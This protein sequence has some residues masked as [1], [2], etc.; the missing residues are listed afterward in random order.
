[1]QINSVIHQSNDYVAQSEPHHTGLQV[2][3]CDS[4]P[5][6]SLNVPYSVESKV[7]LS[8]SPCWSCMRKI[9]VSPLKFS[10]LVGFFKEQLNVKAPLSTSWKHFASP[11]KVFLL[12]ILWVSSGWALLLAFVRSHK[13]PDF[14]AYLTSENG[15][16]LHG[17]FKDKLSLIF[18]NPI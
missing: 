17:S 9:W 10:C 16:T 6:G 8:L 13:T 14:V 3:L 18:K 5:P 12:Q 15:N 7:F 1:M 2:S 4:C 11:F